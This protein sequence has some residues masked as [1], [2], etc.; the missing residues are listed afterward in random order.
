MVLMDHKVRRSWRVGQKLSYKDLIKC[1]CPCRTIEEL[2]SGEFP[3][4][5]WNKDM[6]M[7]RL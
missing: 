1:L 4:Q 2:K 6:R 5:L 3:I 7:V